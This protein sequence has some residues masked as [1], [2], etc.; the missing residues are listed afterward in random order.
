MKRIAIV[1]DNVGVSS[2]LLGFQR[3]D[4]TDS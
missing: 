4:L 3:K 1:E 2:Q